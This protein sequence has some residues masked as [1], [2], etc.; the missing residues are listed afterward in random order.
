MQISNTLQNGMS[1][2]TA[3]A[4]AKAS[5][6]IVVTLWVGFPA[7]I[8]LMVMLMGIDMMTGIISAAREGKVSSELSIRGLM[9]KVAIAIAVLFVHLLDGMILPMFGIPIEELGLEKIFALYI[10]FSEAISIIENLAKCGVPFPLPI[11]KALSQIKEHV[12]R[13]ATPSELE[14]LGS[15]TVTTTVVATATVTTAPPTPEIKEG[16]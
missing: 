9:K 15:R 16:S 6:A 11:V 4:A 7:A 3:M 1:A 2:K 12:P 10:S 14:A 5:A 13:P 8:R